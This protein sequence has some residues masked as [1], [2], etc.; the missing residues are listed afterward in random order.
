MKR[1]HVLIRVGLGLEKLGEIMS[2]LIRS[3]IKGIRGEKDTPE[4]DT[5]GETVR[6]PGIPLWQVEVHM[7]GHLR[8]LE[9]GNPF[10]H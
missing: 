9:A 7:G 1:V 10:I 2:E 6:S 8:V 3:L 4:G 5:I